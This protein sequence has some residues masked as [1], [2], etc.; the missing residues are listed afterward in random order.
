MTADLAEP[1]MPDHAA[2][3]MRLA[4][5]IK[6]EVLF[7]RANRG[8]YSTDA[9]IYQVDPVG[10]VVPETIDDV[11]AAMA[12]ARDE[13]VPVLPR[14]GGTSQCGQTVNRALVIDCSK[15]L[16]RVLQ[17]DAE[18]RTALV[19]PG[20]VLGHLNNALRG[21]KLF[22]PVDPS[23]HA[24]C[25][26]GGMAGNNSC[27]SKSIRYG[28]MADN[29][30]A[31][32]AIL[33]DGSQH[34]FGV[35]PDNLGE[36]IPATVAD[37]IQRL[38]VLGAS[39]ADEIAARFPRQLRRVGGYNIDALT[40][41]ARASGR[42]N[43]ARLLVGSEGTLAF[44]AAIELTLHPVKPRKVLGICQFPTFRKAMEASKHIVALQPEA[45]EL[46]DRTMIDLGRGIPIY[47]ATIEQMLLGEPDSLLIVEFHGHE[48]GPLLAKLAELEA[49]MGDLGHPGVVRAVDPALQADIAAVREAGLNIMMSMKG[50]GK[51][52]SFIE[53]CAVDLDDL[54]DY[55][56]RLNGV[57]ERHGTKGT[58]YAHASVG[59]LHVRP[60]LNMKDPADVTRMRSVAE[61]AFALVR[62]YKGSH[63]GEHGDGLVRSEF[64]EQMFGAR[65]VRA[66]DTVKQ[67]F[68]PIGLMNPNRI[69]QPP[70]MDDRTLFRYSPGYG[71]ASGFTP[72]LD[73]SDH[74]GALGGMLGA[75][76]M[77]N[78]NGTCRGFDTG[79]MCPSYRVTRDEVH[80]TRGR[81]NTLRLALTGQLGADAMTSEPMAEA[82]A[83]CVSCKACKRECPTGVD[84]AKMKIEV[85]AAR[86]ER[87]G[88]KWRET[89][90]AELPRYAPFVSQLPMVANLR[91]NLPPLRWLTERF[92]GLSAARRLPK[93]R[94]DKFLDGEAPADAPW[95]APGDATASAAGGAPAS[96]RG[97][98][99][100]LADTFNRY[101][102]PENLRAALKVLAAAG[103]RAIVPKTGGRP[104]CCGRTWLAVGMVEKAREEAART[105]RH[106]SH[107]LPIIGLEPSCLMTLRDEFRSLLPGA[108]TDRFAERAMLLSEFIAREQPELSLRAMPGTVRVH[109]HCHQ[110]AFGAFPDAL[111]MLRLIPKLSALP[112]ASS[113]CGMAGAFG[114]QAETQAASRAMAE[115]DLLPAVRAAAAHHY[116]VADGTSCRH[117]IRD[118]AGREAVHSV[119]LMERALQTG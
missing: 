78:N 72:K 16:R 104:L 97:D 50:D 34:R 15:H 67:A 89:L 86:A 25:T 46:V 11:V 83:L 27:G 87:H 111:A 55:T 39:E 66:F 101:F 59:C 79:V 90:I 56:E 44:S 41:A 36:R 6:G 8:R 99:Y 70:R 9:S 20:L 3:A 85:S 14:G 61:E 30:R 75:V 108:E 42:D 114:Y 26:I 81:A 24:R 54:A 112:I 84:M 4:R 88:V 65:I 58:W 63:S 38:R 29:V 69:T 113:C 76:E 35:I 28:L 23:T 33:S 17:V 60:V 77:C 119:R 102:E 40:P 95:E 1:V 19:E 13:G 48:D 110:K 37:L 115:A 68:D 12:I 94:R 107:D 5:N 7:D 98:V 93:W 2:F 62:E 18:A 73:W 106:L 117:Q 71:A 109:G 64:H 22:F 47:R 57:F 80:L 105:M 49:L 92:F 52:V 91:N 51:P 118:L 82:M 32:E 10:V 45:V 21:E 31:I 103:Y 96:R 116:I 100:L 43:L 53:D 74:P